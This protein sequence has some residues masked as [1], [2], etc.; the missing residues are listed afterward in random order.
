MWYSYRTGVNYR[1][2]K[3]DS[4]KIG[5]AES[6]DGISW[7]RK[8][9]QAGIASSSVGWD[10]EMVAYPYIYQHKDRKYLFYNGNGFGQSG[11][12]FAELLAAD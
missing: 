6:S 10:S 9:E 3:D 8:D 4:Y 7:T 1:S 5:Y 11:F 12:G 2:N